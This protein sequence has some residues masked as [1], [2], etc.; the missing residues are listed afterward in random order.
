MLS[1]QELEVRNARYAEHVGR[2]SRIQD[3]T[4][5]SYEEALEVA[6]RYIAVARHTGHDYAVTEALALAS[7][8]KTGRPETEVADLMWGEA[9]AIV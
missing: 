3:R 2:V 7:V 1:Q 6:R 5:Y 9:L 8:A 4:G